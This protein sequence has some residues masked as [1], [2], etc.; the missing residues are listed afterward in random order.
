MRALSSAAIPRFARVRRK[1]LIN[2]AYSLR[3]ARAGSIELARRAGL[4]LA[5]RLT[6]TIPNG[7]AEPSDPSLRVTQHRAHAIYKLLETLFCF[8]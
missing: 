5:A 8:F 2:M 4:R 3:K 7:A 6:P 1:G